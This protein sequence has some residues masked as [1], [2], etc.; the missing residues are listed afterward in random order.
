MSSSHP[1]LEESGTDSCVDVHTGCFGFSLWLPI[2][3]MLSHWSG[4]RSSAIDINVLNVIIFL[5]FPF[6]YL[7]LL[8]S[9]LST[10]VFY[11]STWV[12]EQRR[13]S[14]VVWGMEEPNQHWSIS[15]QRESLL[16]VHRSSGDI[17]RGDNC[18]LSG[19]FVWQ[20][21][22]WGLLPQFRSLG[23]NF[24]VKKRQNHFTPHAANCITNSC[25]SL[26]NPYGVP[27]EVQGLSVSPCLILMTVLGRTLMI[28]IPR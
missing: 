11:P 26:L 23:M 19:P 6:F 9:G 7:F 25:Q 2:S 12:K 8:L 16:P 17:H 27:G 22:S 14:R 5:V 3:C 1:S 15:S 10:V 4:C 21:K 28:I 24:D 18:R 20:A 13:L